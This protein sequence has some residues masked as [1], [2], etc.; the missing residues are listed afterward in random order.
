MCE[1]FETLQL[2]QYARR[3]ALQQQLSCFSPNPEKR[4]ADAAALRAHGNLELR[5]R[6][7]E[8]TVRFVQHLECNFPRFS[9][10]DS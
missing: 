1:G 8:L 5:R 10:Q 3:Q 4:Y 7:R 2:A 6:A 9:G